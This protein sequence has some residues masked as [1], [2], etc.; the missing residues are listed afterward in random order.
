MN[1]ETQRCN[2][3]GCDEGVFVDDATKCDE[4]SE[5]MCPSHIRGLETPDSDGWL[6]TNCV[7]AAIVSNPNAKMSVYPFAKTKPVAQQEG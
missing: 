7:A 2:F 4:C 1:T 6:C 5:T 3:K